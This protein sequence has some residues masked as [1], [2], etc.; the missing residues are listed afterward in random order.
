[1]IAAADIRTA[2]SDPRGVVRLLGLED[3]SRREGSCIKIL[4]PLHDEKHPSCSVSLGPDRTV[5]FKCFGCDATGDVLHLIGAVNGLNV[6]RDFPR[7]IEIGAS[8]A[9]IVPG[10]EAPKPKPRKAE[11]TPTKTYPPAA[12]VAELIATCTSVYDDS[13]IHAALAARSIDAAIVTDRSLAFALPPSATLPRWARSTVEV[14][15]S[16][17]TETWAQSGHRLIMPMYDATGAIVTV[18]ARRLDGKHPIK[19]AAAA[20]YRAGG[21]AMADPLARLVLAGK[22]P[23]WWTART[24]IVNE[25]EPDFLTAATHYGDDE[26]APAVLGIVSSSWSTEIAARVPDGCRVVIRTHHDEPG[27][28]YARQVAA[29]LRGRCELRRAVPVEVAK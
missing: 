24:I 21:C 29:S 15:G 6:S 2:L 20:G 8:L 4:C 17:R 22:V 13:E 7:I 11:P 26:A 10:V 28:K 18:R 1:M 16:R 5:R 25:G 12:E 23:S 27:A 3:G 9:G 19:T 14:D